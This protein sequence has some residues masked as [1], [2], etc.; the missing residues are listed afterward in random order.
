[1]RNTAG[2]DIRWHH[3]L[4]TLFVAC[5]NAENPAIPLLGIHPTEMLTFVHRKK[6]YYSVYS[7]TTPNSLNLETTQR[8]T[9]DSMAKLWNIHENGTPSNNKN[10]LKL[11]ATI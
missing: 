5:T 7:C 9:N 8:I 11:H 4:V 3:H 6:R 2:R 1:M 10:D